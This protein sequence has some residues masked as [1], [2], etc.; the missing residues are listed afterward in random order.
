MQTET[1]SVA[2]NRWLMPILIFLLAILAIAIPY[3][4]VKRP[5]GKPAA[6]APCT[7]GGPCSNE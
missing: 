7:V 1:A 5:A 6:P 3:A 2:G 4:L